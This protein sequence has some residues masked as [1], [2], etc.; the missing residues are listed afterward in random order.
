MIKTKILENL[1]K[2][3]EILKE[4]NPELLSVILHHLILIAYCSLRK[5]IQAFQQHIQ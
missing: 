1:T 5:R 3:L 4:K 2:E